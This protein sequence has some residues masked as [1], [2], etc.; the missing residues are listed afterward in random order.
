MVKTL[1][2][3]SNFFLTNSCSAI[4]LAAA[5][6]CVWETGFHI[7]P[8]VLKECLA[9]GP[10]IS[11]TNCLF[12]VLGLQDFRGNNN[13]LLE[14]HCFSRKLTARITENFFNYLTRQD[15]THPMTTSNFESHCKP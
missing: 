7:F 1:K 2:P 12:I 8:D 15:V 3:Y 13:K 9:L 5:R 11:V 4:H 6:N 10:I 14:Q